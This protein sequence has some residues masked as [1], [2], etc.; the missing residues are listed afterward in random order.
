MKS[1]IALKLILTI[2]LL[3]FGGIGRE[4][5]LADMFLATHVHHFP[6]PVLV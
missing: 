4:G 2:L 6:A 3:G 5:K 1:R